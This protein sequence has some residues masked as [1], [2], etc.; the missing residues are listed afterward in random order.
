MAARQSNKYKGLMRSEFAGPG[1][2]VSDVF[3]DL[4]RSGR[5]VLVAED[6]ERQEQAVRLPLEQS[7]GHGHWELYRLDRELFVATMDVAYDEPRRELI[8]G[9]GLIYFYVKLSGRSHFSLPGRASPMMVEG[10][11]LLTLLQAPAVDTF[12]ELAPACREKSV[13]LYCRPEFVAT[14]AR[15][16]GLGKGPLLCELLEQ[17]TEGLWCRQLPLTPHLIYLAKSLLE[18]PY[19]N[20]LRILNAEGKARELL[21]EVLQLLDTGGSS[22]TG[23]ATD[24]ELRRLD[25]A[26][27]ILRTQLNPAPRVVNVAR[28]VGM[29]E[30]KLK[31]SFKARFGVTV[32]DY[33]LECRMRHALELLRAR[34][35]PVAQVAYSVGYR[36]ATSFTAAFRQFYGF[37]PRSARGE[38]H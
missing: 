26:R 20:R 7:E 33:G 19:R 4:V 13:T 16:S 25:S 10:P 38:M 23:C 31:R 24:S 35:M 1:R 37:L 28:A 11:C 3:E 29:S 17:P 18:S 22:F 6:K 27:Q 8:R 34:H 14:L 30:S 2:T 5:S 36:H 15:E 21:C 32:F 12:F 9:D